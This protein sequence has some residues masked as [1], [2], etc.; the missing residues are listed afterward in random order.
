MTYR[1]YD[2]LGRLIILVEPNGNATH[3]NFDSRNNM[4]SQR[5][6]EFN[7]TDYAYDLANR[8]VSTTY[9][10]SI[11]DTDT[12][13]DQTTC[14][15]DALGRDIVCI[16]QEG[17]TIEKTFDLAGRMTSRS[18]YR[19]RNSL[20]SQDTFIYDSSSRLISASKGAYDN[21]VDFA[22][23]QR[24]LLTNETISFDGEVKT[25]NH[26]YDTD[27]RRTQTR[28]P[29]H[30]YVDNEYNNRNQLS[31]VQARGYYSAPRKDLAV[32]TYDLG[33]REE[34][35]VYGNGLE[36]NRSYNRDNTLSRIANSSYRL[37]YDY[38]LNKNVIAKRANTKFNDWRASFDKS[39]RLTN[40]STSREEKSWNLSLVGNWRSVTTNGEFESR[41]YNSKHQ[42][43]S[44]SPDRAYIYDR[45]GNQVQ[46]SNRAM[47]WDIDGHLNSAI[48]LE[49]NQ[50]KSRVLFSY[51]A[52]GRRV[53][54]AS[55]DS[56]NTL[57]KKTFFINSGQR[58]LEEYTKRGSES[59]SSRFAI[60]LWQLCRRT[61]C[62]EFGG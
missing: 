31:K 30:T 23:D 8:R 15:Y 24:G 59:Y 10:G 11:Y 52:L 6:G 34:S 45:R 39:N 57:I 2:S 3:Y 60:F 32:F 55:Y 29:S 21:T 61:S 48:I 53:G 1:I 54:K 58:V 62:N 43:L 46:G 18:Y 7:Q 9:L 40:W 47:Y 20:I 19:S 38:D 12:Q 33:G 51:D 14:Q 27:G 50:V 4:V 49:D 37:D 26:I 13:L 35:R 44:S 5:D 16:D 25:I 41:I 56:D 36:E 22:Y 28:Y 42:L 17:Q